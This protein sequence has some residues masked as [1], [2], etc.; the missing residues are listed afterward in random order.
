MKREE[1]AQEMG[2][3]LEITTMINQGA[4]IRI[5]LEVPIYSRTCV[6]HARFSMGYFSAVGSVLVQQWLV[7]T[8]ESFRELQPLS[9]VN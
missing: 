1:H 8:V 2:M 3:T 4:M 9:N 5:Y 7:G 6:L